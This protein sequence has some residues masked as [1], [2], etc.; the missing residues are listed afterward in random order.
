[1]VARLSF[2][3]VHLAAIL[4][5][6]LL[7]T[8][9]AQARNI[10]GS[11][12]VAVPEMTEIATGMIVRSI[13]DDV[14]QMREGGAG[15]SISTSGRPD[16]GVTTG[17]ETP[18]S[19]SFGY[20]DID[21][22][23]I[24]GGLTSGTLLL[25]HSVR[26][27][28]LV[29]GGLIAER[30]DVD[31]PFNDGTVKTRGLG[32]AL[33]VDY[34]VSDNLLLT[35]VFGAMSLDYDVSRAGGAATGAFK[36]DRRFFDLNGDYLTRAGNA[37]VMIGFG[38]LYVDQDNDAYTETGGGAVA[39]HSTS[40]LSGNLELRGIWGIEG[41]YRPYAEIG[42]R[43]LLS[44][45]GA[46]PSMLEL[47]DDDDWTARIGLG[48]QRRTGGSGFDTGLGANFGEDGFEGLDARLSYTLRF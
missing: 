41:G 21:T 15:I 5:L 22:D 42:S 31:T 6:S 8:G 12:A 13:K 34:S 24:D 30:A 39:A 45:S 33:G 43:F 16:L 3:V 38:L 32:V 29:F 17:G 19:L 10:P 11:A 26:P 35:G 18:L 20:R 47:P 40:R 37:D 28:L 48:M 14:R 36:A 23:R 9:G 44:E 46:L 1:M 2:C 7:A 4:A 25:G 27:G